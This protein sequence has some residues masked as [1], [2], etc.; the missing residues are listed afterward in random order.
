M[1]ARG[2]FEAQLPV[3][4]GRVC[5]ILA[6]L[7]AEVSLLVS[8]CYVHSVRRLSSVLLIGLNYRPES[9]GIAPYT[10]G[11]ATELARQGVDVRAITSFPHYPQWRFTDG[12]AP[13]VSTA[14]EAGV[15]VVRRRHRLPRRPGGVSRALSELSFGIAAASTRFGRPDVVVLVSPALLSSAV[16]LIKARLVTRRPVVVWVQD[17]YTLG[18]R[19]L[20][21]DKV[22]LAERVIAA[23]E[24]RCLRS[25]DAVVVI[26][27]R[28][29]DT[30]VDELGV[31][32]AAVAVVR[33]WSHLDDIEAIDRDAVR[34]GLGWGRSDFVVLHAG[35]MGVKQGLENVID[36]A[37]L[38]AATGSPVRFV[39]LGDGNQRERLAEA[40]AGVQT[41]SMIG[42]LSDDEF[43]NAIGAADALLVNERSGVAGMAVP[44][45]LTSYFTT[46]LP[47][48]AA[49]DPGSVTESEVLLAGAGPVV[50]AGDPQALLDAALSLASDPE[51]ARA[52]GAS[53]RRFRA[54]RLTPRA[55]FDTFTQLLTTLADGRRPSGTRESGTG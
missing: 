35:N 16:A 25:A 2:F 9:T 43:R 44:S 55:S 40:S 41:M 53:G 5:P 10:S 11:L 29:R 27:E 46:G 8:N 47:V 49:T 52:M 30:V 20:G 7:A 1:P 42:S 17:L 24:R 12:G 39:L 48:I 21:V 23:I 6:K 38:A 26:H 45:K 14:R 31:D 32:P 36:A 34:A 22:R 33:N 19:E 54:M 13:S 4:A 3:L 15:T 28:F 51:Q 18:I 37:R 50:P